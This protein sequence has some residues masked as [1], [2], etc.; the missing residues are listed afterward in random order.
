MIKAAFFLLAAAVIAGAFGCAGAQR[1]PAGLPPDDGAIIRAIRAEIDADPEL[2][3]QRI[4]V[5][6]RNG[7]VVLSGRVQSRT[8]ES[9]IIKFSLRV[10][11]V[12]SVKD[13]ITILKK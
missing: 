1:G 2:R 11:G 13:D 6:A 12:R 4:E 7:E 10:K 5:V 9:R 8:Q 3:R